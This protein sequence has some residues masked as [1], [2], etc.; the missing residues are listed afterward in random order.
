MDVTTSSMQA[1]VED[2]VGEL[3]KLV[4]SFKRDY[5]GYM[6]ELTS[7]RKV[8]YPTVEHLSDKAIGDYAEIAVLISK[9]FIRKTGIYIFMSDL[10]SICSKYLQEGER[11][12]MIPSVKNH[13]G[14]YSVSILCISS[15]E[16]NFSIIASEIHSKFQVEEKVL[17]YIDRQVNV[18]NTFPFCLKSFEVEFG[19]YIEDPNPSYFEVDN[20]G[21]CII[22]HKHMELNNIIS[23]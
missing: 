4:N 10:M 23:L 5:L 13:N 22:Q 15:C 12:H 2:P 3:L 17:I 19:E 7:L 1:I 8:V 16:L 20:K 11:V 21:E 14:K 18:V 6:T 9:K